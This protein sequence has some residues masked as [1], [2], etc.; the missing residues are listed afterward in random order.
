MPWAWERLSPFELRDGQR[1]ALAML[2][3]GVDVLIRLPTGSGKSLIM[4]LPVVAAWAEARE[5]MPSADGGSDAAAL[6]PVGVLVVPFR[7]L[8]LDVVREAN[9]PRHHDQ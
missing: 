4:Y 2:A 6:P 5:A 8:A 1:T 9:A 3:R 7:A